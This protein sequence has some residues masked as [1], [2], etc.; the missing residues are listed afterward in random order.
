AR[1]T[2]TLPTDGAYVIEARA[3]SHSTGDHSLSLAEIEPDQPPRPLDF[4]AVLEGAIGEGDP[5]D[6]E[7]RAFDAYSFAGRE[8][9]RVQAI[10]RSGDFDTYLQLGGVDGEFTALASDDDGL[11]EGTDSRLNFT[12]PYD[13]TYVL[14]A[15][16][17]GR[18]E[19]GLYS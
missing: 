5:R 10:M 3:F 8:G 4:R 1:L 16:T 17:Y 13:G 6:G 7:D 9:Q 18:D 11:G 19:E 2:F 14:R 15:M 12:L